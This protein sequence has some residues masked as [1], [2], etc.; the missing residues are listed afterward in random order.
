MARGRP[1]GSKNK[2][3]ENGHDEAA[4][5][6]HNSRPEL[7]DDEKRA[8]ALHHMRRY[9][10]QLAEVEAAKSGLK[11][12]CDLAK[13]DLGKGAVKDIKDMIAASDVK[14][15]RADF[16]RKARLAKWMGHA[17]AFQGD[18]FADTFHA[19]DWFDAGKRHGMQGATCSPPD[20]LGAVS[21]QDWIN[22]WHA[23]QSTLHDALRK[24][25]AA[26]HAEHPDKSDWPLA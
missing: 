7:T 9:Q 18:L 26:A 13:S 12:L 11:E 21:G 25:M 4:A 17:I 23:G 5:E 16:E 14:L 19:E 6:G 2:P 22:G 8:L 15:I 20:H 1:K 3:K 24:R 10:E